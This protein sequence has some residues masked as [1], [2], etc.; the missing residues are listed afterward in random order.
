M[1]PDR[2]PRDMIRR[3][4]EALLVAVNEAVLAEVAERGIRGASMDRIAHRAETG[5]AVLYR[6]W[7]NVRALV[8][9]VFATTLEE[10]SV[11]DLPDHG[12]LRS[13]LL[14]HFRAFTDQMNGPLGLI[15]RELISE[16]VHD[17]SI[18]LDVQ[19][20]FGMKLQAQAVEMIQRGMARGEIPL[21]PVDFYA[22]Q[23]P[24]AFVMHQ[25]VMTG[26]G[27]TP[28]DVEHIVDNILLPLLNRP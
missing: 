11:M 1:T 26:T 20:R 17:N 10:H 3:R 4:G 19:G 8:I 13:D 24:A 23:I 6:R 21:R 14:A 16:A 25:F 27:P 9:D 12:N 18:A 28:T 5:K 7:P 15:L 2:Y 22:L